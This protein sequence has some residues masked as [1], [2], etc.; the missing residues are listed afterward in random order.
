MVNMSRI[1]SRS[2][3]LGAI[4]AAL[5]LLAPPTASAEIVG[6]GGSG[7]GYSLNGG[8]TVDNDVL[9]LTDGGS[10]EARS[11]FSTTTQDITSFNASFTYQAGGSRQ[12]DG[13]TFVLQND[14]AGAAALGGMGGA[15]GYG[16]LAP[17]AAIELNIYNAYTIG[18]NFRTNGQTYN[19][20]A[21]GAVDIASGNK[22]RIDLTYDGTLLSQTLTDLTTLAT[23]STSYVTDLTSVLHGT[24]AYVGFTGASGGTSSIQ[25]ISDFR[26]G[27]SVVPEPHSLALLAAG[28]VGLA[29]YSRSRQKAAC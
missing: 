16:Y 23:Y 25:T 10:F 19:Y 18:T 17:S 22:I 28:L 14:Q 4:V 21:T 13:I 5:G 8:A 26:F 7:G 1:A 20:N 29:G 27:T 6:F 11:A 15:L 2:I 24:T 9:T 12:S 3:V